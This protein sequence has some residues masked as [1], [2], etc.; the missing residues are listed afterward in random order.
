MTELAQKLGEKIGV[1]N[2][3][4]KK[5]SLLAWEFLDMISDN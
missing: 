3:E 5:L 4:L 2:K 1:S